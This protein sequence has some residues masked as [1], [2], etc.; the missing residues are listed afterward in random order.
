[1][2]V[3]PRT[4]TGSEMLGAGLGQG[5]SNGLSQLT[6]QL[7][8]YREQGHLKKVMGEWKKDMST[9]DKLMSLAGAPVSSES[10]AFMGNVLLHMEDVNQKKEVTRL[11]AE[12]TKWTPEKQDKLST[13][14]EK[15]GYDKE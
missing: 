4:P 2:Q 6:Q 13:L 7:A 5:I 15:F 8:Q 11:K 3:I 10:K 1:M 12:Q 9:E 14:L